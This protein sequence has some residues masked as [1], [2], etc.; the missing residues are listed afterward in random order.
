[1]KKVL[2]VLLVCSIAVSSIFA[3]GQMESERPVKQ[4]VKTGLALITSASGKAATSK[5]DG[6]GTANISLVA[7]TITEDGKIES[8]VIDAIQ[9]KVKFSAEGKITSDK[10]TPVLSK[11]EPGTGYGMIKASK[12]GKEWNEQAAA[13]SKYVVGL[14]A[15]EVKAITLS[16]ASRN[17]VDLASSATIGYDDII[18]TIVKAMENAKN[19]GAKSGDTLYLTHYTNNSKSKDATSK[20]DGQTQTYATVAAITV[21]GDVITSMIVDAVQ[22][23]VKFNAKGEVTSDAAYVKTKNELKEAYGMAKAS[24]IGRE[25]YLQ[26]ESFC[27]YATGKTIS[28]VMGTP[29]NEKGVATDADLVSSVTLA[30]ANFTDLIAK[31]AK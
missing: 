14:T 7:V 17:G 25:W 3:Q 31:I 21:D 22:P 1:M 10:S 28:A 11:N 19:L 12:I 8:C 18:E 30:V 27:Q 24:S 16:S 2:T 4:D 26:A 23:T 5:G 29:V 6:Q 13:L 9:G 20:G 15:D